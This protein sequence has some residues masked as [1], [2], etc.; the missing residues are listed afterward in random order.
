MCVKSQRFIGNFKYTSTYE[1][2][3]FASTHERAKRGRNV[4]VEVQSWQ[5]CIYGQYG[6][7]SSASRHWVMSRKRTLASK[8]SRGFCG[9]C[10]GIKI[11][12]GVCTLSW[13]YP[14]KHFKIGFMCFYFRQ[15]GSFRRAR[16]GPQSNTSSVQFI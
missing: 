14:E 13:N 6:D 4:F 12:S 3:V 7:D 1:V 10:R 8:A 16:G 9:S 2:K 5:I 11:D 15:L